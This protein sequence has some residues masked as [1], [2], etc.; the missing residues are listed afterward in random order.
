VR[1]TALSYCVCVADGVSARAPEPTSSSSET[2]LLLR[3]AVAALP[4][5][6]GGGRRCRLFRLVR[7]G[8]RRCSARGRPPHSVA[9][10]LLTNLRRRGGGQTRLR[11]GGGTAGTRLLQAPPVVVG[12]E[13]Q[14]LQRAGHLRDMRQRSRAR[15]RLL[16]VAARG[17]P[18]QPLPRA[19]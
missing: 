1:S 9:Q 2:R 17:A 15:R 4:R 6:S 3:R 5:G 19:P 10:L 13:V 12:G 8:R 16:R 11:R 14:R 18:P 7:H